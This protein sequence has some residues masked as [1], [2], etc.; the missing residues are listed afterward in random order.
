MDSYKCKLCGVDVNGYINYNDRYISNESTRLQN[1]I[2]CYGACEEHALRKLEKQYNSIFYSN[3][4]YIIIFL[5]ILFIT[6]EFNINI[7]INYDIPVYYNKYIDYLTNF[8]LN[9]N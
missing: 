5:F 4:F 8:Y 2:Y 9:K 6:K 3:S 7:T 1:G